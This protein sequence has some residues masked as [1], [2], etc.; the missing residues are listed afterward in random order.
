MNYDNLH[1]LIARYEN[2]ID[3]IYNAD[4]DELFK[5][6]AML[7]GR[8]LRMIMRLLKLSPHMDKHRKKSKDFKSKSLAFRNSKVFQT[9]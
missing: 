5:W 9:V 8:A 4:H 7:P 3:R 2:S 6:R 1:E